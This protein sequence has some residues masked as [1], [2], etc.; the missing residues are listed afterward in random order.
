M[1]YYLFAGHRYYPGG[2]ADDFVE[3]F[4]SLDAA[5]ARAK[6]EK[7]RGYDWWHITD[8]DMKIIHQFEEL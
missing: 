3:K 5:L 7:E 6:R 8:S 1:A 2:G 4:I